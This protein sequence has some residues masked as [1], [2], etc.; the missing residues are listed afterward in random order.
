MAVVYPP[1]NDERSKG[2]LGMREK[3]WNYTTRVWDKCG[4]NMSF[5]YF[6]WH[7]RET[8]NYSVQL[9]NV[10]HGRAG[11]TIERHTPKHKVNEINYHF[12]SQQPYLLM[13]RY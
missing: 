1:E 2:I 13:I 8:H 10:I 7:L 5:K 6:F 11:H 3:E 9:L 12:I 4:G